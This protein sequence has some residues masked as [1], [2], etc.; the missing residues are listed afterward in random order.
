MKNGPVT[1]VFTVFDDSPAYKGGVY[2]PTSDKQLGGHAIRIIGLNKNFKKDFYAYGGNAYG[3]ANTLLQSAFLKPKM[4]SK[5]VSNLYFK[6]R[7]TVPGRG[8]P[9]SIISGKIAAKR[10]GDNTYEYPR[11]I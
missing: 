4:R 7:L 9:P 3:L 1:A 8:M 10:I 2:T 6:G 5:K 11:N